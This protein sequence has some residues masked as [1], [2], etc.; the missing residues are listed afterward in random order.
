MV[1]SQLNLLMK[2]VQKKLNN[3]MKQRIADRQPFFSISDC[4]NVFPERLSFM[5]TIHQLISYILKQLGVSPCKN[6]Y[7]Y[8]R[9]SIYRFIVS[10]QHYSSSMRTVQ[11]VTASEYGTS[12]SNLRNAEH[13]SIVNGWDRRDT[14][15]SGK[16]FDNRGVDPNKAPTSEQLILAVSEWIINSNN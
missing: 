13:R 7:Y 1:S 6:G 3:R 5:K 4:L 16:I 10:E 9:D 8:L 12:L 14:V 2:E 11:Q 15:L